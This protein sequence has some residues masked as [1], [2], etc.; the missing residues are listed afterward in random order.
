MGMKYS[1]QISCGVKEEL[2]WSG[3]LNWK[4]EQDEIIKEAEHYLHAIMAA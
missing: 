1:L 4:K 3:F 2:A